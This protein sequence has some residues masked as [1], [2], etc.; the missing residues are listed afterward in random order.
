MKTVIALVAVWL[1]VGSFVAGERNVASDA[2]PCSRTVVIGLTALLGPINY[3]GAEPRV[4][5]PE[6]MVER[7]KALDPQAPDVRSA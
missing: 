5:C 6:S 3:L 2:D 7:Q 1:M 4:T